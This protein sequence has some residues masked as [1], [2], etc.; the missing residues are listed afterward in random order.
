MEHA[1]PAASRECQQLHQQLNWALERLNALQEDFGWVYAMESL[2]QELHTHYASLA[3]TRRRVRLDARFYVFDKSEI[4]AAF[5]QEYE[6][7]LVSMWCGQIQR[8]QVMIEGEPYRLYLHPDQLC[9]AKPLPL[10]RAAD[11]T[12]KVY[13]VKERRTSRTH[14]HLQ[15]NDPQL[16]GC[17]IDASLGQACKGWLRDANLSRSKSIVARFANEPLERATSAW[18]GRAAPA[19]PS[20]CLLVDAQKVQAFIKTIVKTPQSRCHLTCSGNQTLQVCL[21]LTAPDGFQTE[22]DRLVIGTVCID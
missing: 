5:P 7:L 20:A 11:D 12:T 1:T 6:R 22:L 3:S 21:V 8:A 17:V 15:R 19:V 13:G 14:I 16:P 10:L 18:L 2:L 9:D 4:F